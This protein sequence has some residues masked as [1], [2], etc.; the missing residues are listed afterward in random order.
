VF[1]VRIYRDTH[2]AVVIIADVPA[3]P[4]PSPDIVDVEI[5]TQLARDY[6]LGDLNVRWFIC[7]PGKYSAGRPSSVTKYHEAGFSGTKITRIYC[8]GAREIPRSEI[9][10]AIGRSLDLMPRHEEVLECVFAVGGRLEYP[11]R[12]TR[13]I[14]LPAT[15]R[16]IPPPIRP[17]KC[18][19]REDFGRFIWARGLDPRA[20]SSI[21][22]NVREEFYSQLTEADYH[23]CSYHQADWRTIAAEAVRIVRAMGEYPRSWKVEEAVKATSLTESDHGWLLSLLQSNPIRWSGHDFIEGQHRGCALRNCGAPLIVRGAYGP[24]GYTYTWRIGDDA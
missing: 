21:P 5:A 23:A 13:Y 7:Y 1:W 20:S 12:P 10:G 4:G 2:S 6:E 3:N 11:G 19:Y 16:S 8:R 14:I 18:A 15:A 17:F 22:A 24:R 9:S